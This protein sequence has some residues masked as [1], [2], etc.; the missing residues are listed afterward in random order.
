MEDLDDEI[1]SVEQEI[2]AT[3]SAIIAVENKIGSWDLKIEECEKELNCIVSKINDVD[4]ALS[5]VTTV[6]DEERL[7]EEIHSLENSKLQLNTRMGQMFSQIKEL[8]TEAVQLRNEFLIYLAKSERLSIAKM[9]AQIVLP[10][11]ELTVP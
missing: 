7:N 4:I 11:G 10:N 6:K 1:S 3:K 9:S 8:S 2:S 5:A